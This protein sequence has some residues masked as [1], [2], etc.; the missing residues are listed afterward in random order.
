[1]QRVQP[2]RL[3]GAVEARVAVQAVTVGQRERRLA[4]LKN[5]VLYT[6]NFTDSYRSTNDWVVTPK[7][8]V[9]VTSGMVPR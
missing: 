7:L 3:A 4:Q 5:D 1:M 8:F 2:G 6:T 9:N